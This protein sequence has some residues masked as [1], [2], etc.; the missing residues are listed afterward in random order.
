[1]PKVYLNR[2]FLIRRFSLFT[3]GGLECNRCDGGGVTVYYIVRILFYLRQMSP[4]SQ[5]Y[6]STH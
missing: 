4:T 3:R 2:V 5:P 6:I 1:M